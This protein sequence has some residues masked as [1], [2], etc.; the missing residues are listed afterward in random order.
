M[1]RLQPVRNL[2]ATQL[3]MQESAQASKLHVGRH[4]VYD[5]QHESDTLQIVVESYFFDHI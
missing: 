2:Q 5:M 3:V 1:T 4:V